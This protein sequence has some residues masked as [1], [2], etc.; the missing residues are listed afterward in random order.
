MRIGLFY[1][2][3]IRFCYALFT[4]NDLWNGGYEYNGERVMKNVY[5]RNHHERKSG[6]IDHPS[7][8][9]PQS[10][11]PAARAALF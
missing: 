4:E 2:R 5:V 7:A 10:Q 9:V 6:L 3:I 8:E 1:C 11:Q